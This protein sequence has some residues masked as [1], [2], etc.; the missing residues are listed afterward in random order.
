MKRPPNSIIS[1]LIASLM[2]QLA[3][4]FPAAAYYEDYLPGTLIGKLSMT[5]QRTIEES[6]GGKWQREVMPG[7][8]AS[9]TEG[10]FALKGKDRAGEA[11]TIEDPEDRGLG[12]AC[13]AADVDGNGE[14]DLIFW[15][16]TCPRKT[17]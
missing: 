12:G 16:G 13:F 6:F 4:T 3:S 5:P 8:T 11:W 10:Q 9:V 17:A 2:I 7:V 15:F 14:E 1:L